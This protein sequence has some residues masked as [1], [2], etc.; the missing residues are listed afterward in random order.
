MQILLTGAFGNIGESAMVSL[1]ETEHEIRCLDLKTPNNEKV[2]KRLKRGG[3]FETVWGD[4][5]DQEVVSRAMMNVDCV[6]HLAAIIPPASDL[7]P[8]LT[9]AVNVGGTKNILEV[10]ENLGIAP[11]IVY[12]SSIATYGHCPGRGPPRTASDPQIA[13]DLYTETKIECEYLIRKSNHPWTILRFGVVPPLSMNWFEAAKDPFIFSIPLDQ[14][15]EFVHTRDIGL[16]LSASVAAET[17]GKILLLGGGERCRM[18]YREFISRTLEAVGMDMLP[19]SAF[20]VP[21]CDEDY[22]HTDWMDTKESQSLLQFQKRTFD[23]YTEELREA[24]GFRRHFV[25]LFCALARRKLL[26]A[27]PYYKSD[28]S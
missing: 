8:N 20:L 21:K 27:S 22:F 28:A 13:T 14:R 24:V 12:A 17:V 19:D 3:V 4:I 23:D 25:R 7:D 26:S 2:M 15:M 18:T 16:A 6:L 10:T 11:K 9:R 1:L 5:R